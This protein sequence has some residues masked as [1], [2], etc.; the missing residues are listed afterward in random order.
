MDK[1]WQDSGYPQFCHD[2]TPLA[3]TLLGI[4]GL[5]RKEMLIEIQVVAAL[6]QFGTKE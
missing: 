3:G 5:G 4:S 2:K 1:F 6:P